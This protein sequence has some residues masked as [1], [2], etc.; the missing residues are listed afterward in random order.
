M[1]M[2]SITLSLR[3]LRLCASKDSVARVMATKS[4]VKI[5]EEGWSFFKLWNNGLLWTSL[6]NTLIY[7]CDI[8]EDHTTIVWLTSELFLKHSQL[9][10]RSVGCKSD[11]IQ[12]RWKI[13][14]EQ[15]YFLYM[16]HI[17]NKSHYIK[18]WSYIKINPS[19][20]N[21]LFLMSQKERKRER[22]R[23]MLDLPKLSIKSVITGWSQWVV[24]VL[25]L[26]Q[27]NIHRDNHW[28]LTLTALGLTVYT[29][30]VLYI[31]WQHLLTR[32]V[33]WQ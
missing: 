32:L 25:W 17:A 13:K 23:E 33:T 8:Q 22:E 5:K 15:N 2:T 28:R 1:S 6:T 9:H 18:I 4:T 24:A 27:E 19:A 31:K 30:F 14:Y 21:P 11:I 29:V 3:P 10:G 20:K 26:K 7:Y 16:Y 12:V